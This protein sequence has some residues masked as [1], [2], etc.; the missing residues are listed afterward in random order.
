MA[1]SHGGFAKRTRIIP[2][3]DVLAAYA[4]RPKPTEI[5]RASRMK[6]YR[7]NG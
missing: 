3:G 7:W 4:E 1:W 6:G 5:D 2:H